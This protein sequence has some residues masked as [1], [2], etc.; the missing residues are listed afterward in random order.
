[1][2]PLGTDDAAINEARAREER[3]REVL[4]LGEQGYRL[5]REGR[6]D[7]AHD[8]FQQALHVSPDLSLPHALLGMSRVRAGDL[9][10][11]ARHL[12]TAEGLGTN[13]AWTT[14][15]EVV[16][17]MAQG[18][19][20]EARGKVVARVY[21][22]QLKRERPRIFADV[23]D[24]LFPTEPAHPL[25]HF[26]CIGAQKSGTTWLHIH[27]KK[28]P[29]VFLPH[30]KESQHF[31]QVFHHNLGLY[32]LLFAGGHDRIR[33]EICPSYAPLSDERIAL[34]ASVMPELKIIYVLRN[35]MERAFSALRMDINI[36]KKYQDKTLS[37]RS[38]MEILENDAH[39]VEFSRYTKHLRAW[40]RHFSDE[41]FLVC[42]FE[43]IKSRPMW[44][45]EQI[46]AH[47]NL[48]APGGWDEQALMEK[49]FSSPD[50]EMPKAV[51]IFLREQ[52]DEE[53]NML[54]A[55]FGQR[56][57]HWLA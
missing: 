30:K 5:L 27:M 2:S 10:G 51:Q 7:E 25:P 26:F 6:C 22:D 35:P 36:V 40:K 33:G 57:E 49:I 29:E 32:S 46:C 47:L 53:L 1:M 41:R 44:M 54:H 37:E 34:I 12:A 19:E 16:L 13:P 20:E 15:L 9:E 28:H 24:E 4:S 52:L 48:S 18:K 55:M 43:D 42:F 45:L 39:Y 17:L 38:L 11:A 21:G 50:M 56:V 31:S 14:L 23:I 8:L 3:K